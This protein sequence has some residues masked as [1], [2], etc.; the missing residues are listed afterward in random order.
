MMNKQ[1]SEV[2]KKAQEEFSNQMQLIVDNLNSELKKLN[3][4]F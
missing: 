4:L 2:E 1:L 3:L